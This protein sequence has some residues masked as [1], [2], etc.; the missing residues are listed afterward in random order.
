[1]NF[2][3]AI[4]LLWIL[5]T[6]SLPE[7]V[8]LL[9]F[10]HLSLHCVSAAF[11]LIIHMTEWDMVPTGST[12]PTGRFSALKTAAHIAEAAKVHLYSVSIC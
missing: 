8:F 10:S 4:I 11:L 12:Y 1:M 2:Y 7:S 3:Y 6:K 9:I 5:E